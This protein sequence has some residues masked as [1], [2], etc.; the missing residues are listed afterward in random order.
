[1]R[2]AVFYII[3]FAGSS[4]LNTYAQSQTTNST[5]AQDTLQVDTIRNQ[6]LPTGIRIGTDVISIVKSRIQNTF[7]GREFNADIDFN[8]YL[9]AIDYGNWGRSFISSNS[10]YTNDGRYWRVGAEA[11]F[12]TRDPERNVFFLG[13]RYARSNYSESMSVISTDRNY[14]DLTR[15]FTSNDMKAR[16][17]ELN[18]GLKVKIWKII[19]MGYTGR[20]KFGLKKDDAQSDMLTHDVPGYGRTDRE[21]AWGFTYHLYVRIPFRPTTS[22]Q[23]PKK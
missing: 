18:A 15:T 1:M 11:N 13:L 23:P 3:F 2:F 4:V 8:R 14:G 9:L 10:T 21:T 16:W 7:S 22:I 5:N 19:W 17:F 6:F 20:L 12:L